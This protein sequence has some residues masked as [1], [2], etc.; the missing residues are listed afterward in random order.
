MFEIYY[1]G[2]LVFQFYVSNDIALCYIPT[3]T[4][5]RTEIEDDKETMLVTM[6]TPHQGRAGNLSAT[7]RGMLCR[8]PSTVFTKRKVFVAAHVNSAT[9]CVEYRCYTA[10]MIAG[11]APAA[12]IFYPTR[13]LRCCSVLKRFSLKLW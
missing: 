10:W 13:P 6:K 4:G 2:T 1:L 11:T 7:L 3:C 9:S 12:T 5:G 8:W